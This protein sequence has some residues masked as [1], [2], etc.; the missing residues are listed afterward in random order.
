MKFYKYTTS[1]VTFNIFTFSR[2]FIVIN[3]QF[4]VVEFFF[5]S[6]YI[7]FFIYYETIKS[8]FNQKKKIHA[9]LFIPDNFI[10]S[11]TTYLPTVK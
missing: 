3:I 5:M 4:V 9:S 2:Y 6:L 11:F 1:G 10:I 8:N 7:G